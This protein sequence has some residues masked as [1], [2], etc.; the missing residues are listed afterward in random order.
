MS[1][2]AK[3][4]DLKSTVVLILVENEYT[5]KNLAE[6]CSRLS[7]EGVIRKDDLKSAWS[8]FTQVRVDVILAD[9]GKGEGMTFVQKVRT[10]PESPKPEVPVLGLM[11]DPSKPLLE[12]ARD[13]GVTEFLAL[14]TSVAAVEAKV[15]AA[16][17]RPREMVRSSSYVGPSRRRIAKTIP[18]PDRR[19][20][21]AQA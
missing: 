17:E 11:A 19:G 14:P 20:K 9:V 2:I 12:R 3:T 21:D 5:A 7:F 15:R 10:D 8:A 18:G 4:A 13:A 6:I 16:L 1:D